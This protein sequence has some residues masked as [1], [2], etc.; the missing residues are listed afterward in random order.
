VG[1]AMGQLNAG[2]AYREG[3]DLWPVCWS[4]GVHGDWYAR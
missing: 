1:L 2:T 3:V 4:I